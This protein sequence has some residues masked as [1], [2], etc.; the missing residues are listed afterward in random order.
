MWQDGVSLSLL[1]RQVRK[2]PGPR[3]TTLYATTIV[4]Y[5]IQLIRLTGKLSKQ[6]TDKRVK[7]VNLQVR[8]SIQVIET[9]NE[10]VTGVVPAQEVELIDSPRRH[11]CHFSFF[12]VQKFLSR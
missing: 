10:L 3:N 11:V 6:E 12:A 1:V 5:F 7:Q 9:G 8:T 4:L 2:E